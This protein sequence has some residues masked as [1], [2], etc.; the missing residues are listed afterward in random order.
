MRLW[1]FAVN[2]HNPTSMLTF[3]LLLAG[4][5]PPPTSY[6][7]V[8]CPWNRAGFLWDVQADT[9]TV[10]YLLSCCCASW[11][12]FSPTGGWVVSVWRWQATRS[13]R[14]FARTKVRLVTDF[15]HSP[16]AQFAHQQLH[17]SVDIRQRDIELLLLDRKNGDCINNYFVL[18]HQQQFSTTVCLL[19]QLYLILPVNKEAPSF[20]HNLICNQKLFLSWIFPVAMEF[21][22]FS[23][24]HWISIVSSLLLADH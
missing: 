4:N 16:L 6:C 21:V 8:H 15:P 3:K 23:K 2:S 7:I 10:F 9:H 18:I 22:F 24:S 12:F 20:P 14:K 5:W 1:P 11:L 19:S 17:K 13:R